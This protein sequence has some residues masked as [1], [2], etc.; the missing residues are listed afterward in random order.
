MYHWS[1]IYQYGIGGAVFG[2]ST[3]LLVRSRAIDLRTR[4][5]RWGLA[6]LVGGFLLYAAF[7]AFSIFVLPGS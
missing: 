7:H 2:I 6:I 3:W 1:F 4:T 5:G